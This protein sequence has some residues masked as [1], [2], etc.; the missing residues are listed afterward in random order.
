MGPGGCQSY[1]RKC[2]LFSA[3]GAR[4]AGR[5]SMGSKARC[6]SI[7]REKDSRATGPDC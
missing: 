5:S 2:L 7:L 3:M 4:E 6:R 1:E